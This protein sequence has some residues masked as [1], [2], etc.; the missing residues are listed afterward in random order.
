VLRD[1]T[2]EL[3]DPDD[4]AAISA[5]RYMENCLRE[6]SGGTPADD[7]RNK[8]RK[9]IKGFFSRRDCT[10]LRV[11]ASSEED[12][13]NLN[14]LPIGMLREGFIKGLAKLWMHMFGLLLEPKR[15]Y[16]EVVTGRAL[17]GLASA[18][19]DAINSDSTPS[20]PGA[21][22]N[23]AATECEVAKHAAEEALEQGI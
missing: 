15:L 14:S 12:L 20:I 16:G 6:S 1:F 2:L 18:Y 22:E 23:V 9:T 3:R 17:A 10:V 5:R 4:G 19:V 11:P 21:W 8:V 7:A 13:Q